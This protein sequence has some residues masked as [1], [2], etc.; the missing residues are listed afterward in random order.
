MLICY[1]S[2]IYSDRIVLGLL[3]PEQYVSALIKKGKIE[4]KPMNSRWFCGWF[5]FSSCLACWQGRC[6]FWELGS[7][8]N[9]LVTISLSFAQL[10]GPFYRFCAIPMQFP[11]HWNHDLLSPFQIL[12]K[13]ETMLC[14]AVLFNQSVLEPIIFFWTFS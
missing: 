5:S 1:I 11:H 14:G 12:I 7:S 6:S 13:L 9:V 10:Y 3:E 8:D 2:S 4:M